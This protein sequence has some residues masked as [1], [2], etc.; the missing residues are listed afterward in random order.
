MKSATNKQ[1]KYKIKTD[2][3]RF[4]FYFEQDGDSDEGTNISGK[5]VFFPDTTK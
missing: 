4:Y 3:G 2:I 1:V 5:M